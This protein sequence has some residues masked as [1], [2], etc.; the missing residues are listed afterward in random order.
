[1]NADQT[2]ARIAIL[3]EVALAYSR[4]SINR[5]QYDMLLALHR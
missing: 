2:T 4:G 1:M 3:L 5:E